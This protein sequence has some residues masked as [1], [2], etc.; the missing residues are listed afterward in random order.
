MRAVQASGS[1]S[2]AASVAGAGAGARQP[3]R[4]SP[5]ELPLCGGAVAA[6]CRESVALGRHAALCVGQWD[7]WCS[8][9]Q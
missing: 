3:K 4:P 5:R 6:G 8:A 9:E 7:I 2:P 1:N